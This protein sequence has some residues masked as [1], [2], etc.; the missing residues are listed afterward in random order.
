V[1][2]GINGDATILSSKTNGGFRSD[3]ESPFG[4]GW[5]VSASS[6]RSLH[7]HLS[8]VSVSTREDTFPVPLA[9]C[10]LRWTSFQW[11]PSIGDFEINP[12]TFSGGRQRVRRL[13]HEAL[14]GWKS[15]GTSARN[16]LN[17]AVMRVR[18]GQLWSPT[19]T[20]PHPHNQ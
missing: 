20:S 7:L 3:G 9:F 18:S 1:S 10:I 5:V 2:V 8:R 12:T 19:K 13:F 6:D 11:F 14:K 16:L 15:R 4:I 17:W